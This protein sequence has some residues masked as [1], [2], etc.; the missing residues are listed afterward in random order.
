MAA[1]T[2]EGKIAEALFGRVASLSFSP[3]IPVA[4]PEKPFTPPKKAT[5]IEATLFDL[6]AVALAL[7]DDGTNSLTGLLQVTVCADQGKGDAYSRDIAGQIVAHFARGTRMTAG[8][9]LVRV[10][11]PPSMASRYADPPWSR[12][13]VTIR[14]QAFASK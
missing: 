5:W 14:F 9:I 11:G 8:G 13:P 7:A 3:A 1:T 4:Y 2:T 10:S 6:P 12:L